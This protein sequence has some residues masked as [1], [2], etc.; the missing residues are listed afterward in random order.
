MN[1]IDDEINAT[2]EEFEETKQMNK[3]DLKVRGMMCG[4]CVKH[5]E[6]ALSSMNGVKSVSV[7]LDNAAAT[8]ESSVEI[9]M[10]EFKKVIE[11]AGYELV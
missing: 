8:V 2:N 1:I 9:T 5:V 3:Y 11:E 10:D 6:K 4:N 7:D